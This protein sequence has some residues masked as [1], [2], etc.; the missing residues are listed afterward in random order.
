M[1]VLSEIGVDHYQGLKSLWESLGE[2]YASIPGKLTG[3]LRP[4][5]SDMLQGNRFVT[6]KKIPL[7]VTWTLT[8]ANKTGDYSLDPSGND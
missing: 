8:V 3:H 6:Q 1:G 5:I 4:G 2:K 7:G